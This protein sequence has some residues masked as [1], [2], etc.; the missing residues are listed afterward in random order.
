MAGQ[1]KQVRVKWK[2]SRSN[3]LIKKKLEMET[4]LRL[5]RGLLNKG[6]GNKKLKSLPQSHVCFYIIFIFSFINLIFLLT[7]AQQN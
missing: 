3:I 4:L 5:A 7:F 2:Y 1:K 6:R